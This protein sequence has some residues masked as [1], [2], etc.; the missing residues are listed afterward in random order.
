MSSSILAALLSLATLFQP[1]GSL[2]LTAVLQRATE[3]VTRYEAELGNLIGSEEYVQNS[4]WLEN[5]RFGYPRVGKR[6]QRRISSDFLIVQVG[7]EWAALRKVNRVDGVKVKETEP[8]FEDAFDNSPEANSTRLL[9]M[10][11]ESTGYNIGDIIREINLP[12]FALKV[13]RQSEVSRFAFE[14]AGSSKIEGIQ[15]WAI[16]FR[17]QTRPTLVVGGKD[18]PLYSSGTLWIDPETGRVLRTEFMVENPYTPSRIKGAIN[19]RYSEGKN[20]KMLVPNLM[21]EHYESE[22]NTVD[23]R[24]FYTNFRPFEVDVKFEIHPP[25]Q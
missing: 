14:R 4:A 18:E 23:C 10:K 20:V 9:V 12:T 21:D 16:R 5:T 25:V 15:T 24:A 1:Q 2:D 6:S 3:Y 7:P 19:V 13:L 22:F 17:E 11:A 8:S